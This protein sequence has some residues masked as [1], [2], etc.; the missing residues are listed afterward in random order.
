MCIL[1]VIEAISKVCLQGHN[2]LPWKN[3]DFF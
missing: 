3:K 1:I 2:M